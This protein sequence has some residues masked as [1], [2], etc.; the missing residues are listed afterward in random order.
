MTKQRAAVKQFCSNLLK[1]TSE[2]P[3]P[4]V[5]IVDEKNGIFALRFSS[6][7]AVEKFFLVNFDNFA[8][9]N[10][11]TKVIGRAL[12]VFPHGKAVRK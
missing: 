9:N 8:Q 6:F 10:L 1:F 7:E 3:L 2:F 11:S 5:E 12:L 4:H